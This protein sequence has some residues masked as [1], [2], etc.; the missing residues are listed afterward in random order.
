[1]KLVNSNILSSVVA[2]IG[3]LVLSN[4]YGIS[5]DFGQGQKTIISGEAGTTAGSTLVL[6]IG[7]AIIQ[8][9]R[10]NHPSAP[11]TTFS[12]VYPEALANPPSYANI[13]SAGN[14]Y[15]AQEHRVALDG[16]VNNPSTTSLN[17]IVV[18]GA[19]VGND[20][21]YWIVAGRR[22]DIPSA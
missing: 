12:V 21:S 5:V 9:G 10:V 1:M 15:P 18:E 6:K 3:E 19:E 13:S 8:C 20:Y 4:K 14:D 22:T 11:G 2:K 17:A 7:T 16:S